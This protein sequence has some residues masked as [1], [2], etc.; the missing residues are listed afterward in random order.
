MICLIGKSS[1]GKDTLYKHLMADPELGLHPIIPYTTRPIRADEHDGVEY[2]FTDELGFRRLQ[3]EGK[4]VEMRSYRTVHGLW[5]Y[6]TVVDDKI[7]L[8]AADYCLIGT[9]QVY[10]SL[11]KYYGPEQV[12]PVYIEVEDGE[13]LSRALSRERSQQHPRYEEMCRRFLSDS[14]DFSEKRIAEAG[15]THRFSN[16]DLESCLKEIGEYIKLHRQ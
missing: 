14:Q 5:R 15:I 6:F 11:V 1:C 12:L 13:R 16:E 8:T 2:F 7:D 9:L 10:Q 4:V 3:A